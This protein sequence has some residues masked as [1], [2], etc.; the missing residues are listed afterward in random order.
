MAGDTLLQLSW[1]GGAIE[2]VVPVARKYYR[3]LIDKRHHLSEQDK[4]DTLEAE[5][6]LN[7]VQFARS[8]FGWLKGDLWCWGMVSKFPDLDI[9]GKYVH[10]FFKELWEQKII[11]RLRPVILFYER[12]DENAN[13]YR[14]KYDEENKDVVVEGPFK[15]EGLCW[16][17]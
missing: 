10:P 13:M 11:L 8:Y 3:E 5:W 6:F 1:N 12:G 9:F 15:F 2:D 17:T 7:D 4:D 16:E 14:I